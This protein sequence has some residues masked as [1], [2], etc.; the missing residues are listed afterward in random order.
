MRVMFVVGVDIGG[1]NMVAAVVN[2]H[3]AEVVSRGAIR[4]EAQR[5][6][7]DGFN[8]LGNLIDAVVHE[9]GLA[10]D[11]VGGIG[12]GCTGP[13]DSISGRVHNPYTLPTWDDAPLV[14]H[15]AARF[16][17]PVVL[18]NDAHVAALGEHWAGSGRGTQHMIYITVG[19]GIGSGIILGGRLYRGVGLMAGEVGHQVIDIN[20]PA[21][22]CGARGCLEMLAAGPAIARFAAERATPDGLLLRLVGDDRSRITA[23]TVYEAATEGDPTALEILRQTGFYLGV[24]VANLLN[25]L[26]PEIVILGGGVMQGWPL[27]APT[28]LETIGQREAV[29]PFSQTRIVPASLKLNAGVIGAARGLLDSVEGRL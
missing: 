24:G 1:T 18:L 12:V 25:T 26:A 27:I 15:L 7:Q 14:D 11:R 16:K 29:V 23:Q 3:N 17:L 19:T 10:I 8:R 21:C 9:A 5:G 6:P 22:Y 13:L 20:G 28:M 4:T 2:S